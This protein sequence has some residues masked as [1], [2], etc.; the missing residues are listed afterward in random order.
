[1]SD[2]RKHTSTRSRKPYVGRK[3]DAPITPKMKGGYS[4]EE[5]S[6]SPSVSQS[7]S[8]SSGKYTEERTITRSPI[9]ESELVS[10]EKLKVDLR[11]YRKIV[12]SLVPHA[13][14]AINSLTT[15]LKEKLQAVQ[16][17]ALSAD[18]DQRQEIEQ[19]IRSKFGALI[20]SNDVRPYTVGSVLSAAC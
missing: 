2:K 16:H 7:S 19:I 20:Q 8:S 3:I 1:M 11:E 4:S 17:I 6:M 5:Y 12:E 15:T 14:T 18:L 10:S 9:D 13:R